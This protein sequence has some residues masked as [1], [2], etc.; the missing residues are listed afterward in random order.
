MKGNLYGL[1]GVALLMLLAVATCGCTQ[2]TPQPITAPLYN[3]RR[4][5]RQTLARR[6]LVSCRGLRKQIIKKETY[7]RMNNVDWRRPRPTPHKPKGP[8]LYATLL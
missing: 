3:T 8:A 4:T 5:R 6:A 2:P 1:V 7:H